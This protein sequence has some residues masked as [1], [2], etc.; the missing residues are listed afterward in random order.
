MYNKREDPMGDVRIVWDDESSVPPANF[1]TRRAALGARS[2][3]AGNTVLVAI[4]TVPEIGVAL[5]NV[6][7]AILMRRGAVAVGATCFRSR[8]NADS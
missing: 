1:G 5:R 4:P 6:P 2:P 8:R 7:A 3:L